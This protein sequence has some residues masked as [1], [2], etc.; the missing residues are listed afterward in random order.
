MKNV[1]NS[2][3]R[4][5]GVISEKSSRKAASKLPPETQLKESESGRHRGEVSKRNSL[6]KWQRGESII[7]LYEESIM[8]R[9]LA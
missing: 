4:N 6:S 8:A 3:A 9:K 1:C 5:S 7:Y 2:V